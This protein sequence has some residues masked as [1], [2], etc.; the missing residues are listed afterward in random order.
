[1]S[2][3]RIKRALQK[4]KGRNGMRTTVLLIF[5]LAFVIMALNLPEFGHELG[6]VSQYYLEHSIADTGALSTVGAIVW[7]Y[8]GYDTLGEITIL[9]TA[10]IG[11]LL[12]LKEEI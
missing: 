7:S 11:I 9:L 4:G 2:G 10:V 8:R 12:L 6:D 5:F 3:T 1:M